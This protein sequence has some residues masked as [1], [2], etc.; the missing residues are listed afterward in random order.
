MQDDITRCPFCYHRFLATLN[1]CPKCGFEIF[2]L[3][4][5]LRI[6]Q[7]IKKLSQK[8]QDYKQQLLSTMQQLNKKSIR[9]KHFNISLRKNT[10]RRS[11][12]YT[13]LQKLYPDVYTVLQQEKII[14][15][16]QPKQPFSLT[17]KA[18][19]QTSED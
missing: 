3:N 1:T 8:L 15:T 19:Q 6:H 12:N 5:L 4:E 11:I 9:H 10:P 18:L 16:T 17:I 14:T 7:Q 2:R 13:K